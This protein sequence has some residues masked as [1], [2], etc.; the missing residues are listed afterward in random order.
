MEQIQTGLVGFGLS[1]KVFHAPFLH[2]NPGFQL[3]KVVERKS[4]NSKS[5]Y[6]YVEVVKGIDEVLKDPDIELMV[7][8][9]PNTLHISMTK[10]CLEAGKHV[11][12]EKPFT[13][14]SNEALELIKVAEQNKKHLFVFHN[15]RWDGNFKTIKQIIEQGTLGNIVEYEAHFDRF[16]PVM[17]HNA[18]RDIPLPGAGILYDLGSHLIDQALALFGIPEY[19]FA[20]LQNQRRGSEVDDYFELQL[21]Y[22]NLKVILK[23]GMFVKELGPSYVIHGTQGSYVKYGLDP[24]EAMLKNGILPEGNEWGKEDSD[25]YGIINSLLLTPNRQ[26][27]ETLPGNYH[28]FYDNVYEVIRNGADMVVTPSHAQQ[29]IKI[30]ELAF[31]SHETKRIITIV[32]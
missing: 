12:L 2:T 18:W 1:G 13:P 32:E 26:T 29:V 24:Q 30:I 4:Q 19:L 14:T 25:Q 10:Q 16:S 22:D 8:G 3:R 31:Q 5:I 21:F 28:G 6:P 9:V 20:D 23:A 11:V 17:K 27:I 15:R 7:L